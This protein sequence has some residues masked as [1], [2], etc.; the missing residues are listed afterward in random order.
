MRPTT[1]QTVRDALGGDRA[2]RCES[3]AL[4]L[5][6]YARISEAAKKENLKR[7]EIESVVACHAS[8]AERIP[9]CA[10]PGAET[11]DATLGGR[12]IINQAGGILE[13]AGLCLH[14][15]FGDPTLPGSAVKGLA[16]HAAWCEWN[17]AEEPAKRGIAD[18]IV[19]VFGYPTGDKGL[20]AYIEPDTGKR[21]AR[22]GGVAFLAGVPVGK[23]ALVVE[24]VNCH[25]PKYYSGR[26]DVATDDEQPNPQFFPAVEAGGDW[27]FT[28][29]PLRRLG[30]DAATL[31]AQARTWLADALTVHGAGAKTAAGYGWFRYDAE[32]E[33]RRKQEEAAEREEKVLLAEFAA[34]VSA[35]VD[36]LDAVDPVA[37]ANTLRDVESRKAEFTGRF[38]ALQKPLP[39]DQRITDTVNRNRKRIPVASP[40]DAVRERWSKQ[41]VNA[42]ING[43]LKRFAAEKDESRKSAMVQVLRDPSGIGQQVWTELKL[44]GTKGD[45]AKAVE[46]IRIHCKTVLQL[47][48]MP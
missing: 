41:A 15:H 30:T 38:T 35:A 10:P 5:A 28:L 34:W 40:E 8:H 11:L 36:T 19:R 46:A 22:A 33:A 4:R 18:K 37:M 21:V 25:H 45:L 9:P 32:A 16:R 23:P 39:D 24:I 29:A 27:R 26:Q 3:P 7:E 17:E 13:N 2:P 43:E 44:K 48:K 42:I 1:T 6:K 47:G 12:L 20:D 14:R 31:L